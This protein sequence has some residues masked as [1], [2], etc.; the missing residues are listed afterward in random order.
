LYIQFA[1]IFIP[2]KETLTDYVIENLLSLKENDNSRTVGGAGIGFL[3][4]GPIGAA[5]GAGI[6]ALSEKPN[7]DILYSK[8][9]IDMTTG[10]PV[11]LLE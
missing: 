7:H 2:V 3:L 6:G 5:A 8:F 9:K 1:E 4:L 11:P 10:M